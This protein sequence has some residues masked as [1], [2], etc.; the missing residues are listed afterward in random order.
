MRRAAMDQLARREC[1]QH[2]LQQKLSRRFG[3]DDTV[4]TEIASVVAELAEAGLQSDERFAESL[5]RARR[6]R[7]HGPL[8]I[9]QDLWQRGIADAI[10][11]AL[12]NDSSED[13]VALASA[14]AQRKFGDAPPPDHKAWARRARF[15]AS[16]GFPE[17]VVRAALADPAP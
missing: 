16:R 7:G 2:E 9:R 8:R 13:W 5:A 3:T 11:D 17:S 6:E 4:Q 12:V 10:I 14:A 15:L 1:S